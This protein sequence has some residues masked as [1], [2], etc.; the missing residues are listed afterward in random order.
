VRISLKIS[1]AYDTHNFYFY[2][3]YYFYSS[4]SE[5]LISENTYFYP[6]SFFQKKIT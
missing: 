5:I 4:F 1:Y 6:S 2:L 3:F